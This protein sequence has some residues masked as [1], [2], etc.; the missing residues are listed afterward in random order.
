PKSTDMAEYSSFFDG[1]RRY[2]HPTSVGDIYNRLHRTCGRPNVRRFAMTSSKIVFLV[3]ITIE[4]LIVVPAARCDY[5]NE[6][7][8]ITSPLATDFEVI[9]AGNKVNQ[10]GS[11]FISPFNNGANVNFNNMNNTTVIT[12][13]AVAGQNLPMGL[14]HFGFVLANAPLVEGGLGAGTP[15]LIAKLITFPSP[16]PPK[17]VLALN[18]FSDET[19]DNGEATVMLQNMSAD[20]MSVFD[21]GYLVCPRG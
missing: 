3:G 12:F 21:V 8:M 13:N 2:I 19:V 20:T 16:M 14:N 15:S 9:L 11:Q 18:L 1:P 4:A 10:I 6:D 17:K 5:I 7:I